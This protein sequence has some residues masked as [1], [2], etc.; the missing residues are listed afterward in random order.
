MSRLFNNSL[1]SWH[2]FGPGQW[3][4][5]QK[6]AGLDSRHREAMLPESVSTT[7]LHSR[8]ACS[9]M[10]TWATNHPVLFDL[11]AKEQRLLYLIY[12]HRQEPPRILTHLLALQPVSG[13][14]PELL[15]MV[16]KIHCFS[17]QWV[18]S[19]HTP[20]LHHLSPA[21]NCF[22]YLLLVW[23]FITYFLYPLQNPFTQTF[24]LCTFPGFP[25]LFFSNKLLCKVAV[26]FL[27]PH[28]RKSCKNS[29]CFSLPKP[30]LTLSAS[31]SVKDPFP[32]SHCSL[33]IFVQTLHISTL[34]SSSIT[35]L[36]LLVPEVI[37]SCI[38]TARKSQ[39]KMSDTV[40][41]SGFQVHRTFLPLPSDTL[42]LFLCCPIF[43]SVY[44]L[45]SLAKPQGYP[46][47][48]NKF[49]WA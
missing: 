17:L 29:S 27:L 9:A 15:Y 10:C 43:N 7:I 35:F 26:D 30:S 31:Q 20:V 21:K 2:S 4:R 38:Y 48:C 24:P 19:I 37:P 1:G 22:N 23:K 34:Q 49:N 47:T 13:H 45:L 42:V 8:K 44:S 14:V 6:T 5:A 33:P 28:Y 32:S 16:I 18:K 40:V 11:Q 12:W 3:A 25:N 46:W 41:F 36:I 39:L